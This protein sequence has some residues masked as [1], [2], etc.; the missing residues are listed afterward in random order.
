MRFYDSFHTSILALNCY[1]IEDAAS[2]TVSTVIERLKNT[3]EIEQVI[4]CC[5]SD[6]DLDVYN[7]IMS[8]NEF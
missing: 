2:I 6:Y 1:P 4:F 7:E 3:P 8:C 5:I